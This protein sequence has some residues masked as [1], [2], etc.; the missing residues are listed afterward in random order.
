M[1]A[2]V[3][4]TGVVA[5]GAAAAGIATQRPEARRRSP[6]GPPAPRYLESGT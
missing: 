5:L 2:V 1:K 3:R 6:V 4:T